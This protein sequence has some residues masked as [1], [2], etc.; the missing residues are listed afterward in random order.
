MEMNPVVVEAEEAVEAS[1][2][3]F[4]AVLTGREVAPSGAAGGPDEGAGCWAAVGTND[5]LQRLADGALDAL[6]AVAR[7]E[8][9][10]AAVKAQ[11][12]SLS[13]CLCK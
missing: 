3:A 9:K 8:A 5:G 4:A 1:V 10:L 13:S 11:A 12:V 2:A 7:S 6:A